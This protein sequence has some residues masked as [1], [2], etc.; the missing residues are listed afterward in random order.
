MYQLVLNPGDDDQQR[1]AFTVSEADVDDALD[2]GRAERGDPLDQQ[3]AD[4]AYHM[5]MTGRVTPIDRVTD[6]P[7]VLVRDGRIAARN[8]AAADVTE[9]DL[10]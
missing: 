5:V 6:E 4:A 2:Y 10:A 3:L 1:I 8:A 9:A 7:W